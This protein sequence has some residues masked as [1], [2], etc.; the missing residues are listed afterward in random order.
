MRFRILGIAFVSLLLFVNCGT[1]FNTAK[2][3]A[4]IKEAFELTKE[5]KLGI[6][7]I[8]MESENI[9]LVRFKLYEMEMLVR[10]KKY[11]DKGWQIVEGQDPD[12]LTWYPITKD[13]I[14]SIRWRTKAKRKAN[15]EEKRVREEAIASIKKVFELTKK[16]RLAILSVSMESEDGNVALVK[17]KL[18]GFEISSRMKKHVEKGWQLD[19]IYHPEV[20]MWVPA[21]SKW[22]NIDKTGKIVWKERKGKAIKDCIEIVGV[23]TK[24]VKKYYQPRPPKLTIVP[25]ISFRIKNVSE[26]ALRKI[27]FIAKFKFAGGGDLGDC[28]LTTLEELPLLPG[29]VSDVITLMTRLGVAGKSVSHFR[30]SRHWKVV[31]VKVFAQSVGSRRNLLGEWKVSRIIDLKSPSP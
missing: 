31:A 20:E 15:R 9:A 29:E 27:N 14:E 28:L 1:K 8:F 5:D 4:I 7:E 30:N 12:D 3:N 25:T 13:D 21:E 6:L 18:N 17:F 2:A 16:N 11:I 23:E 24:W 10:M 22:C 19:E 26:E